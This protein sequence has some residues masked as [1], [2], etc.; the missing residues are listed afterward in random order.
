M[1]P[2]RF[3]QV[4]SH[5]KRTL[6][7]IYC[8]VGDEAAWVNETRNRIL[9]D[10]RVKGLERELAISPADNLIDVVENACI[11]DLFSTHKIIDLFCSKQ[12]E[13]DSILPKIFNCPIP[14][15]WLLTIEQ[16]SPAFLNGKLTKQLEDKGG[17]LIRIF[18]PS[19]AQWRTWA[20]DKIQESQLHFSKETVQKLLT[21][22]EGNSI[23][24]LNF[25]KQ[26]QLH[27]QNTTVSVDALALLAPE[28]STLLWEFQQGLLNY[29]P[30]RTYDLLRRLKHNGEE[31]LLVLWALTQTIHI[32][33]H[34]QTRPAEP[35]PR[36]LRLNPVLKQAYMGAARN[37]PSVATLGVLEQLGMVDRLIKSYAMEQ[38]WQEVERL[39]IALC[40]RVQT[41]HA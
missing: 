31:I 26:A 28:S 10:T 41:H 12:N 13:L 18:A 19:S 3:E 11:P 8:I 4:A 39:V 35:L 29:P 33:A 25:L 14:H 36:A 16:V 5:L 37:W 27:T 22:F 17:V 34:F 24:V 32:V 20:L 1:Q 38:A 21:H 9:Q 2:L 15:L 23:G 30:V 40:T 7:P 6:A